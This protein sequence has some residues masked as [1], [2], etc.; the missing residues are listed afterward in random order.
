[1]FLYLT[2]LI[3]KYLHS[4]DFFVNFTLDEEF[5]EVIKS[6]FRDDFSYASFSEG[7]KQKIDLALLF[8]WREVATDEEQCCY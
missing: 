5:N 3:N 2:I 1:M 4:M 7:E 6:R 8:T